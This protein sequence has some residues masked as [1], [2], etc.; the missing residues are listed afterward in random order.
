[1]SPATQVH[2]VSKRRSRSISDI[3]RAAICR[4]QRRHPSIKTTAV[5]LWAKE[6]LGITVSQ[7]TVSRLKKNSTKADTLNSLKILHDLLDEYTN[8]S[9][10]PKEVEVKTC[11]E[12]K[13]EFEAPFNR[14]T[15]YKNQ[16]DISSSAVKKYLQ[17]WI[18]HLQDTNHPEKEIFA[19]I[20]EKHLQILEMSLINNKIQTT[21]QCYFKGSK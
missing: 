11:I 20:A 14:D 15:T 1:M 17:A 8:K 18:T 21:I 12:N 3:E 4:Y 9:I 10:C 5:V 2:P 6:E 19:C 16:M 13:T 7:R